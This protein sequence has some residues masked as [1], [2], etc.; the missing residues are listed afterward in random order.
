MNGPLHAWSGL[1]VPGDVY[2]RI[3]HGSLA[4]RLWRTLKGKLSGGR[5]VNNG[6]RGQRHC[7][8]VTNPVASI[9]LQ[10]LL[11]RDGRSNPVRK[12]RASGSW[13]GRAKDAGSRRTTPDSS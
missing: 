4:R 3:V 8:F 1:R 6:T 12:N 13:Q 9:R 10:E 7:F 11:V 2:R 5:E